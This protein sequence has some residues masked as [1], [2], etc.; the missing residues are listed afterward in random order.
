MLVDHTDATE[1]E[2]KAM[3]KVIRKEVADAC[4]RAKAG[5]PPDSIADLTNNIYLTEDGK[6]EPQAYIRMPDYTKSIRQ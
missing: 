2:L 1:E 6:S 4:D 3:E 5:A